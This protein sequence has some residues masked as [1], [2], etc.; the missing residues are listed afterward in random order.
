MAVLALVLAIPTPLVGA[1]TSGAVETV[2]VTFAVRQSPEAAIAVLAKYG[3][4]GG[5]LRHSYEAGGQTWTGFFPFA[6]SDAQQIAREYRAAHAA[7]TADL[8]GSLN[9][10]AQ[11][12]PASV[13]ASA[14]AALEAGADALQRPVVIG[15]LG[16]LAVGSVDRVRADSR[17]SGA[18]VRT[19]APPVRRAQKVPGALM[20]P[21]SGHSTYSQW[22]PDDHYITVQPSSMSGQ[23]YISN[24]FIWGSGRSLYFGTNYGFEADFFLSRNDGT[25]LTRD[26]VYI[27]IPNVYAS[28]NLPWDSLGNPPYLDTR[29]GDYTSQ[30]ISYTMGTPGGNQILTGTWYNTYIRGAN[31]DAGSDWGRHYP[32]QTVFG[33]GPGEPRDTWSMYPH[34]ACYSSW[35]IPVPVVSWHWNRYSGPWACN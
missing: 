22:V 3:L 14:R 16:I 8:L 7:M 27:E 11:S 4:K 21:L 10:P 18:T 34:A 24:D 28:T 2:D 31:G 9:D 29:Y 20:A 32:D 13:T 35:S 30:E 15:A 17:V 26:V 19:Q 6:G 25:Y 23:R 12:R 5:Q 33:G 1:S